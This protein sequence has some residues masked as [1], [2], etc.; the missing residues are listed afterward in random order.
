VEVGNEKVQLS[1]PERTQWTAISKHID[2][3]TTGVQ[4]HHTIV[5]MAGVSRIDAEG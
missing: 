1:G 3:W 4:S 2:P 5:T